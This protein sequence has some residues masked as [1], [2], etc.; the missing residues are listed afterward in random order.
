MKKEQLAPTIKEVRDLRQQVLEM[1]HK[2]QEKR[3]QYDATM[4]GMDT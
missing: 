2:H 3:K 4:M 1:E